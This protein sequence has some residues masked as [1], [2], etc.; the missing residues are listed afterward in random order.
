MLHNLITG[1]LSAGGVDWAG[2]SGA[3]RDGAGRG[4]GA[5]IVVGATA[6]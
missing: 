1:C 4:G 3:G 6:G 2:R 5:Y